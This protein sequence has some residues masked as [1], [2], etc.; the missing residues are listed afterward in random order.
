MFM[1]I[2]RK[3]INFAAIDDYG[4]PDFSKYENVLLFCENIVDNFIENTNTLIY[5]K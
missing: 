5:I 4:I 3:T 2:I 1:G